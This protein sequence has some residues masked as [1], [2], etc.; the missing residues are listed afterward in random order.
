MQNCVQSSG[1]KATGIFV[2]LLSQNGF[3]SNCPEIKFETITSLGQS[4][5]VT[6]QKSIA[7]LW[8]VFSNQMM[9][10]RF[11]HTQLD[12]ISAHKPLTCTY[13]ESYTLG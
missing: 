5:K 7:E 11:P 9:K 12:E 13:M 6:V 1:L 8:T 10:Y 2:I 3:Q 4:E